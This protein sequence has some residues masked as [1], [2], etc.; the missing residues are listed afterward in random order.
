MTWNRGYQDPIQ[1]KDRRKSSK[2][3]GGRGTWRILSCLI[4]L[5]LIAGIG[6]AYSSDDAP[7][8]VAQSVE[9]RTKLYLHPETVGGIS[10]SSAGGGGGG[11][12][13][14][15]RL[16]THTFPD[17]V[18]AIGMPT[19][20][21]VVAAGTD[22][23]EVALINSSGSVLWTYQSGAPVTGLGITGGGSA[24]AAGAG[25]Q[26]MM[27]DAHGQVLWALDTGSRVP[28]IGISPE[29]KCCAAGTAEGDILLVSSKGD[30]LWRAQPGG[31]VTAVSVG[32]DGAFT[33]VGTEDGSIY[34]LN[35]RGDL[36]WTYDAG[37]AVQGISVTGSGSI[38]AGTS[39][40]SLFLLN[41]RGQ[42]KAVWT[43]DDPINAVLIDPRGLR[44][45]VG[46]AEGYTHLLTSAG[47]RLWSSERE[48]GAITAVA[49]S[50][51]FDYLATGSDSGNISYFAFTARTPPTV[52]LEQDTVTPATT[53]PTMPP[54]GIQAASVETV[55]QKAPGLSPAIALGAIVAIAISRRIA[56]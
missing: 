7:G 26:I 55:S 46:T 23:G 3:S 30:L 54:A 12:L 8:T 20:G 35:S 17:A 16:W 5:C 19:D 51:P 44:I 43:G 39:N 56:R 38:T 41:S 50:S 28:G 24:L 15:I 21:S 11:G 47:I 25:S 49:F 52:I 6:Q 14:A 40:S 4:M 1:K 33:A 31:A 42:G 53:T 36:L 2:L 27:L 13:S 45:G 10:Q 32:P 9:I 22:G 18:T 29:G 37:S 48:K 34:L